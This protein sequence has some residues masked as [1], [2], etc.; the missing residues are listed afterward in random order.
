MPALQHPA[1]SLMGLAKSPI[2]LLPLRAELTLGVLLELS[3]LLAGCENSPPVFFLK[4]DA[5]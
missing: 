2:Y 1:N 4:N 3:C 5:A